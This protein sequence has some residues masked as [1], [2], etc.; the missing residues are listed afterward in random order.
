MS[1]SSGMFLFNQRDNT[2]KVEVQNDLVV[3]EYYERPDYHECNRLGPS[4]RVAGGAFYDA[5]MV[6]LARRKY[7][8]ATGWRGHVSSKG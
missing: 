3:I 5:V 1:R 2:A 7:R 6:G 4:W 8:R